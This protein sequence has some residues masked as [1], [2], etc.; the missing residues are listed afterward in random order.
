MGNVHSGVISVRCYSDN[1]PLQVEFEIEPI[2]SEWTI[3]DID[4]SC[5]DEGCSDYYWE[6]HAEFEPAISKIATILL[7]NKNICF[8]EAVSEV[9]GQ[10]HLQYEIN[11]RIE[12]LALNVDIEKIMLDL[13]L[14]DPDA[15]P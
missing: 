8:K 9:F 7:N 13:L 4:L 3:N 11:G 6:N 1:E 5:I 15:R 14:S 10:F 2:L 12:E